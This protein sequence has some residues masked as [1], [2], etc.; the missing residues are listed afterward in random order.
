MTA[1]HNAL[2][3]TRPPLDPRSTDAPAPV[4][5]L[6]EDPISAEFLP[7]FEGLARREVRLP[8]CGDCGRFHWY[9]MPRCPHCQGGD[10]R[11]SPI[12]SPAT[13]YSWTVVRHAFQP[14]LRGS[15]PYIVAL[16]TF[17]DA[18]GVR[19]ITN[20]VDVEPADIHVGMALRPSFDIPP[21]ASPR[22]RFCPA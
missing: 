16:V 6:L 15:L 13:L 17:D 22:V 8:C 14:A 20:L 12:T 18:P 11:W 5:P 7:H 9:P 4:D 21:D 1:A 2:Q 3:A 10:I 19:L